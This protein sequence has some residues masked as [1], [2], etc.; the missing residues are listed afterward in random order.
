MDHSIA[1]ALFEKGSFFVLLD[2]PVGFSFG[3]D[4]NSWLVG[5]KF[6]GLK[7]IPP[8]PHVLYIRPVASLESSMGDD[9]IFMYFNF[10][11]K[12]I[13]VKK[14]DT[15][16]RS[17]VDIE[18]EEAERYRINIRALDPFLGAYQ[19]TPSIEAPEINTFHKWLGLSS[20]INDDLIKSLVTTIHSPTFEQNVSFTPIDF[21]NSYPAGSSPFEIT[22]HNL[23]K[24][25]L[26]KKIVSNVHSGKNTNLLGELEI[27][28]IHFLVCQQYNGFQQWKTLLTLI[29]SCDT[30]LE[31][32]FDSFYLEF[33]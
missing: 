29:C 19:L 4:F 15:S 30:V 21:R 6:K 8:G 3:I 23:D 17:I 2:L 22:K 18:E 11:P 27:S 24:S 26:F 1:A 31:Q 14:W 13:I 5:E 10:K 32:L 33:I 28:F 25:W 9:T 20:H 7:L 12:D 16:K